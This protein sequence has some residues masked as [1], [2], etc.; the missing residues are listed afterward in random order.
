MDNVLVS[1]I[2]P[3]FNRAPI[4]KETLDSIL[5]QTYQNWECIIVDDGSTDETQNVVLYYINLDKRFR[6]YK[7]PDS[8]KPGGNGAR[9]YGF[10]ISKGDYINWFDDD[11][12]MLE[13]FLASKLASMQETHDFIISSGFYVDNQLENRRKMKIFATDH[14]FQDYLKWNIEIITNSVLFKKSFLVN[15]ELFSSTIKRGQETELFSRLFFQVASH[16]YKILDEYLFL[17]RQHESTKTFKNNSYLNEYKESQAYIYIENLKRSLLLK[18]AEL[19]HFH[20][21]LLLN[22]FFRGLEHDHIRNSKLILKALVTILYHHKQSLFIQLFFLG[23]LALRLQKGR[24][25][26]ESNL[27][28]KRIYFK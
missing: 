6:F 13:N 10:D 21:D 23:H 28:R 7:R 25:K 18:D 14:L 2:I 19:I 12:V 26:I 15:K 1:I 3:T 17:Y 9:N 4:I 5:L 27:R 8:Y 24:A 11:D 16:K 22:L 20:Y